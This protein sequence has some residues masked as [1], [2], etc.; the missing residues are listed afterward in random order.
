MKRLFVQP[1]LFNNPG[2]I[3]LPGLQLGRGSLIKS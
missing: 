2:V 1:H 3:F